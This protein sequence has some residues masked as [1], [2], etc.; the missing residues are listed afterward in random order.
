LGSQAKIVTGGDSTEAGENS[1]EAA[2]IS[3]EAAGVSGTYCDR[4]VQHRA[5]LFILAAEAEAT[6][7]G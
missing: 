4:G 6:E 7:A 1:T 2:M 5:E 3:T